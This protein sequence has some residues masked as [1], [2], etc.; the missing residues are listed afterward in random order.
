MTLSVE[1]AAQGARDRI[2]DLPE[3]VAGYAL[4]TLEA[5]V[6]YVVKDYSLEIA[7]DAT[8]RSY[9]LT[10]PTDVTVSIV[11]GVAD[12]TEFAALFTTEKIYRET[13]ELSELY[14]ANAGTP[15]RVRL[16]RRREALDWARSTDGNYILGYWDGDTMRFRSLAGRTDDLTDTLMVQASFEATIALIPG[17]AEEDFLMWFANRL[18]RMPE[19]AR[20]Q[21]AP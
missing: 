13:F 10:N 1:T 8:R 11:S 21:A 12:S 7:R 18:R 4:P 2:T 5:M 9:L 19:L 20:A 14:V 17:R 3:S 6:P 15:V 16:V